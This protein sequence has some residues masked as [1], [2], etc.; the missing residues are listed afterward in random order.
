M[1]IYR[2]VHVLKPVLEKERA[3]LTG[4]LCDGD[5][6]HIEPLIPVSFDQ[7]QD[8]RVIGDPQVPAYFIFLD[9][10]GADDNDD[11]GLIAQFF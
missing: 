11:L 1:E 6:P 4:E 7:A 2:D 10:F 5:A 3:L 8:V 9:I